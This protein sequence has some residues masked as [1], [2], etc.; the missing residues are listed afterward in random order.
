M[1]L[2]TIIEYVV[3]AVYSLFLIIG[4]GLHI[5]QLE[6]WVGLSFILWFRIGELLDE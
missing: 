4:A 1:K 3:A 6:W 5:T 2:K